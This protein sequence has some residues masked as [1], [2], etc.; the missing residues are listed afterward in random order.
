VEEGA[1]KFKACLPVQKVE[2]AARKEQQDTDWEVPGEHLRTTIDVID[3]FKPQ[4]CHK[5]HSFASMCTNW[6]IRKDSVDQDPANLISLSNPLHKSSRLLSIVTWACLCE[7]PAA[8]GGPE[9]LSHK[10]HSWRR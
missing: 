6:H 4:Y 1:T 3:N 10:P 8:F 2:V 9:N 5:T 7:F